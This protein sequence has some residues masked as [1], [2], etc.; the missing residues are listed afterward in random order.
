LSLPKWG[1]LS[2]F[3]KIAKYQYLPSKTSKII[4]LTFLSKIKHKANNTQKINNQKPCQKISHSNWE[5]RMAPYPE[6]G[7]SFNPCFS[8]SMRLK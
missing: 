8:G 5:I 7:R 6:N 4:A 3:Q 2:F 1:R